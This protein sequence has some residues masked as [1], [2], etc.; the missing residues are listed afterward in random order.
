MMARRR[1]VL[2][3]W[4][5]FFVGRVSQF[6]GR[7]SRG[8]CKSRRRPHSLATISTRPKVKT[9]TTT[10]KKKKKQKS[11]FRSQKRTRPTRLRQIHRQTPID[12]LRSSYVKEK[13]VT[14]SATQFQ[15]KKRVQFGFRQ[16]IRQRANDERFANVPK[17]ENSVMLS[18]GGS[19]SVKASL[20][21]IKGSCNS[22]ILRHSRNQLQVVIKKQEKTR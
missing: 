6:D 14:L 11:R 12:S 2:F 1:G 20:R 10:K 7:P 22:L 5:T 18:N 4:L 21:P 9:T 19:F 8:R 17:G 16:V 15:G 13:L 3:K